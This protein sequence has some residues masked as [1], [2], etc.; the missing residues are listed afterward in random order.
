VHERLLGPLLAAH[1][2]DAA[3]RFGDLA[4]TDSARAA[5]GRYAMLRCVYG[6]SGYVCAVHVLLVNSGFVSTGRL[7]GG[8]MTTSPGPA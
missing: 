6:R 1:V 8:S 5:E 2:R 7:L 3:V 4:L